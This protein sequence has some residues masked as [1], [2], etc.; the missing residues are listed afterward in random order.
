M[1]GKRVLS[2]NLGSILSHIAEQTLAC[3][4]TLASTKHLDLSN[5][6]CFYYFHRH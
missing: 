2:D 4:T 6:S 1:E 5:Y 3:P